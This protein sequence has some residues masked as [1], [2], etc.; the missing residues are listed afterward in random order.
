MSYGPRKTCYTC[1]VALDIN[2]PLNDGYCHNCGGSRA[3]DS[4]LIIFSDH[5]SPA[6]GSKKVEASVEKPAANRA[7][8]R[9]KAH[10]EKKKRRGRNPHLY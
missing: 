7:E 9:K 5:L 3:V 2:S 10:K 1:K 8:R 6:E 4:N